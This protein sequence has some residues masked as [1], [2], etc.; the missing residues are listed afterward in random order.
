MQTYRKDALK[1]AH[2]SHIRRR[3]PIRLDLLLCQLKLICGDVWHSGQVNVAIYHHV[4]ESQRGENPKDDRLCSAMAQTNK[5]SLLPR[6]RILEH[7]LEQNI[8]SSLRS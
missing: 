4:D 7:E 6:S 5:Y 8:E 1:E 3:R 2:Q